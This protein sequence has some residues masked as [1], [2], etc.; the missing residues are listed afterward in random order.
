MCIRDRIQDGTLNEEENWVSGILSDDRGVYYYQMP[1][2]WLCILSLPYTLLL[3][4]VESIYLWYGVI[5]TLFV[6]VAGYMWYRDRNLSQYAETASE[7]IKALGNSYYAIYRIHVNVGTYEMTKE[8]EPVR[9]KLP[10]K[11]NYI[12]LLHLL[13]SVMDEETRIDFENSFS[14]DNIKI[15]VK[16]GT[17]DFGGD[18]LRKFQGRFD[19]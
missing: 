19:G 17:K 13:S 2:G 1:N 11:G 9:S 6:L 7:T 4:G 15:L 5:F 14:L 12:D 18:F 16:Q 8:S 10:Y 3:Q